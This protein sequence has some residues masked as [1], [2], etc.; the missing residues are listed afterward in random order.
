MNKETCKKLLENNLLEK[1]VNG[2]RIQCR[3]VNGTW[4]DINSDDIS[5]NYDESYYRIKPEPKYRPFK[6][7]ELCDLVGKVVNKKNTN[8]YDLIISVED[9]I[10]GI[11]GFSYTTVGLLEYYTFKDGSP[12]GV[13]DK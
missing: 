8:T 3:Y 2:A 6:R 11:R 9:D 12:C 13:L 4:R 5:F 7:E 10:V 1:W